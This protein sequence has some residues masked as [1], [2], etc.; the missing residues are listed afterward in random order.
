MQSLEARPDLT[1]I[2]DSSGSPGSRLQARFIGHTGDVIRIQTNIALGQNMLVSVAGQ[3][4]TGTGISPVLG[5]YRVCWS[6]IAGIRKY[7]A[8][9]AMET[10]AESAGG[11]QDARRTLRMV[12]PGLIST[13]PITMRFFR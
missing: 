6:R 4:D 13:R 1:V 10:P 8:E 5:Q 12:R 9:L 7:H 3:V 11:E 2:L